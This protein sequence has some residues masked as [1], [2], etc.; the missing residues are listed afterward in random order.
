MV[1]NV[2]VITMAQRVSLFAVPCFVY[3]A[4]GLAGS[5][6]YTILLLQAV[7]AVSVDM[8][9]LPGGM[10]VSETLILLIFDP[11][12]GGMLLP[13]MGAVVRFVH[14]GCRIGAGAEKKKKKNGR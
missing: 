13:G 11:I 9:P 4:L 7:V 3:K 1:V 12:F 14:M 8:L 10:G 2:F 6:W 5:R